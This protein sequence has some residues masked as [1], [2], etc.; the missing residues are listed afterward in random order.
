M[1]EAEQQPMAGPEFYKARASMMRVQAQ[2]ADSDKARFVY[3]EL[4][5]YWDQMAQVMQNAVAMKQALI[6]RDALNHVSAANDDRS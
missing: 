3:L 1:T 4:A 2:Y 6:A 5:A